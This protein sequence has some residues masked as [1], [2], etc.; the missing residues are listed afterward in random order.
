LAQL[1]V[2]ALDSVHSLLWSPGEGP[3]HTS[4]NVIAN[5]EVLDCENRP[6]VLRRL[7]LVHEALTIAGSFK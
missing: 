1:K 3:K 6:S 4:V 2:D 5:D 7:G